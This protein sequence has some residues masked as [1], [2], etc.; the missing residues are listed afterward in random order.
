MWGL[1]PSNIVIVATGERIRDEAHLRHVRSTDPGA[2]CIV[3]FLDEEN[4]ADR[5]LLERS[6][7]F[8]DSIVASDAMHVT[9]PDGSTESREWPLP[10]GGMTHPRTA[11]TFARSLRTMV[12]ERGAWTWA[13]AFRRCSYLPA[14]VL[15][16]VAPAFRDKGHLGVGADADIVV[17]DPERV[18]DLATYFDSTR[19]SVGIEQLLVRG[20]FVVRDGDIVLDAYPGRGLRGQVR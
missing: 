18:T 15:D 2:A 13:E 9:W 1:S 20:E 17:I 7:G 16:L 10:A 8:P 6:L 12:R 4:P 5:A 11:G 19:P 14:R 3:E